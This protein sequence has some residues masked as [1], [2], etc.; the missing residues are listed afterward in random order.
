MIAELDRVILTVDLPEY[1]LRAGDMGTVVLVHDS[2]KG[3]EVEFVSLDGETVAVTSLFAYQ[4]RPIG[5]REIAHAR[6][7]VMV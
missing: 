6:P 7:L 1:G 5:Q 2:S 3:F 4:V